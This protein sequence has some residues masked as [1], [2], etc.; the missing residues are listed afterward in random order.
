MAAPLKRVFNHGKCSLQTIIKNKSSVKNS[1]F[2][3]I[4]AYLQKGKT[5]DNYMI[6]SDMVT[7]KLQTEK[8]EKAF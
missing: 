3:S 5:E 7:E 1:R 8:D 2:R 4:L 6:I